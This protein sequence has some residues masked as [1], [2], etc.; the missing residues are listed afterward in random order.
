[1]RSGKKL[2]NCPYNIVCGTYNRCLY[3][4][5]SCEHYNVLN[6][7]CSGDVRPTVG[8]QECSGGGRCSEW[9]NRDG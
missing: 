2:L 7:T 3:N 4:C 8:F 1:M 6:N 5:F 9:R